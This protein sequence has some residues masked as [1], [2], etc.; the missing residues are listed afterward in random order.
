MLRHD[1]AARPGGQRA[2]RRGAEIARVAHF[3]EHDDDLGAQHV[4]GRR[5]GIGVDLQR[6]ALV[7]AAAGQLVEGV[8]VHGL[9]RQAARE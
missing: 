5:V 2:A 9:D 1:E 8:R 7:V 6:D 3:V 4:V